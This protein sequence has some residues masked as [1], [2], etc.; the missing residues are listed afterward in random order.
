MT[1]SDTVPHDYLKAT[2]TLDVGG[3]TLRVIPEGSLGV[4]LAFEKGDTRFR[5]LASRETMVALAAT[6]LVQAV[7]TPS[8]SPDSA[9]RPTSGH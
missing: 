3:T 2:H 8:P 5:L 6:L 1:T 4:W 7:M 9:I